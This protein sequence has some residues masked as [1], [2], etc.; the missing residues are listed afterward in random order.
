MILRVTH[1]RHDK[2]VLE[3]YGALTGV[4]IHEPSVYDG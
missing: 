2:E 3:K 4:Y 1:H